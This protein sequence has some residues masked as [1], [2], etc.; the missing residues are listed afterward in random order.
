[1]SNPISSPGDPVFYLHHTWLDKIWWDWQKQDLTGRLTEMG[2][3]NKPA[4][5]S[6]RPPSRGLPEQR[7]DDVP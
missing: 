3:P 7:P 5:R 6:R 2:G 1:M 4:P